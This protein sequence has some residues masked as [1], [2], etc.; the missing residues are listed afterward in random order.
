MERS[1]SS[2]VVLTL[3]VLIIFGCGLVTPANA[4]NTVKDCGAG[5]VETLCARSA[6]RT[7]I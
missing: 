2:S 5:G 7:L 6:T 1:H 3:S 4:A